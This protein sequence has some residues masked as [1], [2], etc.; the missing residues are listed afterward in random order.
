MW[1][2]RDT[3]SA[4]AAA[5]AETLDVALLTADARLNPAA[6]PR[7]PFPVVRS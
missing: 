2:L 4:Y 5:L 7:C 3:V 6:G 1:D